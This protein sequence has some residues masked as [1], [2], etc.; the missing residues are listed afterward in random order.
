[1]RHDQGQ[2]RSGCHG[3]AQQEAQDEGATG[4]SVSNAEQALAS[5]AGAALVAAMS[6]AAHVRR[7]I[8]FNCWP[9]RCMAVNG[10]SLSVCTTFILSA[11]RVPPLLLL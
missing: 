5:S 9:V 6:A 10:L 4:Q 8:D 7:A 11:D 2:P 3:S 1:M